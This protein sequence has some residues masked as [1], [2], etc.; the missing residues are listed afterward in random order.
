MPHPEINEIF[1]YLGAWPVWLR[2]VVLLSGAILL[3][4]VV[5]AVLFAIAGRLVR[6]RHGDPGHASLRHIRHPLR[7][8]LPLL[9]VSSVWPTLPLVS[10]VLSNGEHILGVA[11]IGAL[12]WS[13]I[14]LLLVFEE[15]F[16]NRFSISVQDNLRARRVRTQIQI[17]RR[18]TAFTIALLAIA[19]ALMTIPAV[20]QVGTGLFA[21][22]GLAGLVA[23]MAA[24]PTLS[25]L[26]AGIQIALTEPI[27]IEDV[28]IVE[29]EWGWIEE[30]HTTYVVVRIWDLRRLVVPISYFIEKPFQNWTRRSADLLGAVHFFV[31]YS[32]P[33]DALRARLQQVLQATPLWDG[34]VWN[35]QVTEATERVLKL[36]ALMSAGDSGK[37]WDLRCHVREQ[38]VAW[39]QQNYP[40]AL[41]RV[42]A[43]LEQGARPGLEPGAEPPTSVPAPAAR[44]EKPARP[45]PDRSQKG[46]A[47]L[48]GELK[49]VADESGKDSKDSGGLKR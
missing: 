39:L 30:I 45:L 40:H 22:A 37:A 24:R 19:I 17:L 10:N 43:E 46:E 2:I 9:A 48:E 44:P 32:V 7:W 20:R 21:S 41:P 34:K 35:L 18:I 28:V 31:D 5:H 36:R 49:P 23:G 33:V 15:I 29:N 16:N 8:L 25:N 38:M 11:T 3:A 12:A 42:R 27:R 6:R 26:I 13:V 47:Q 14:A 4:L 1:G